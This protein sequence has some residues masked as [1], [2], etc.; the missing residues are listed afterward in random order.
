MVRRDVQHLEV[1]DVVLDL[2]ALDDH[3]AEPAEDLGDGADRLG[4][5]M[6]RAPPDRSTRR[7]HVE[8]LGAEA[9][10]E[11][12]V[13]ER[14]PPGRD[15]L[16][17]AAPNGVRDRPDVRT[18]LGRQRADAPQDR[19]QAALLA[20]DVEVERVERREVR[21]GVNGRPRLG[22]QRVEVAG[23]LGEVHGF[24]EC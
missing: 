2:G 3:E 6:E 16:L 22:R 15:G 24:A 5:G 21:R 1:A 14:R 17:D 13:A 18:L 19:G 23:E 8:P 11:L 9:G 12:S 4:D 20:E 7:R 10:L